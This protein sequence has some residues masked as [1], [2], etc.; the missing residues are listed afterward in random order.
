MTVS[1]VVTSSGAASTSIKLSASANMLPATTQAS[2]AKTSNVVSIS[3]VG[4]KLAATAPQAYTVTSALAA[5]KANTLS[6]TSPITITDLSSAVA[7]NLTDL[8]AMNKAGVISN[9][10]FSDKT[11]ALSM[12]RTAITGPLDDTLGFLAHIGSA[13]KL[14]VS[15]LKAGEAGSFSTLPATATVSLGVYKMRLLSQ[16]PTL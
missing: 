5:Y 15:N 8:V 11:P 12:N 3:T 16:P 2:T 10:S 9:L 7:A 13:Y 1:S 6:S 4:V 14:T